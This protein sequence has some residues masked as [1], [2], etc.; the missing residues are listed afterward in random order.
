M[1]SIKSLSLLFVFDEYYLSLRV[2]LTRFLLAL[3]LRIT[4]QSSI[5]S[6][7]FITITFRFLGGGFSVCCWSNSLV[8]SQEFA[9][10]FISVAV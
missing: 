1:K 9:D 6:I 2:C 8:L 7:L 5:R 3:Y 4:V 10:N